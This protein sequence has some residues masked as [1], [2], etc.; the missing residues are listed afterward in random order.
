[1]DKSGVEKAENLESRS[2]FK[3]ISISEATALHGRQEVE[4]LAGLR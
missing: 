3:K 4:A 2:Q 1:M